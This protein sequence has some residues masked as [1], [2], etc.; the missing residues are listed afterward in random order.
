MS[1]EASPE[2]RF[3]RSAIILGGGMIILYARHQ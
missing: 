1:E 3:F 2:D